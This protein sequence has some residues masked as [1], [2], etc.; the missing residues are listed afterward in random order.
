MGTRVGGSAEQVAWQGSLLHTH[1]SKFNGNVSI[2]K[3]GIQKY[4][5]AFIGASLNPSQCPRSPVVLMLP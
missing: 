1:T 5:R 3:K 2:G 4:S